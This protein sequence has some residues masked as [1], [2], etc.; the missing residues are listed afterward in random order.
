MF[1]DVCAVDVHRLGVHG[2]EVH[3]IFLYMQSPDVCGMKSLK[4]TVHYF[5]TL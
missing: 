3:S 5:L 1:S 4:L 2:M